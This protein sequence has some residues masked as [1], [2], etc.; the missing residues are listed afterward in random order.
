MALAIDSQLPAATALRGD[1]ISQAFVN[2]AGTVMYAVCAATDQTGTVTLNA[3]TYNGVALTLI[4]SQVSYDTNHSKIGLYRLLSPAT[5]SNTF[6]LSGSGGS[7]NFRVLACIMTFTGN[8]TSTPEGTL[9]SASGS[10]AT[11]ATGN[12]TNTSGNYLISGAVTGTTVPVA[13][14]GNTISSSLAGSANTGG[15]NI[16]MQYFA[17]TGATRNMQMTFTSDVWGTVGVEV[18]APVVAGGDLTVL[19]GEPLVSS[20]AF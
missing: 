9:A 11:A 20:S 17:A 10:S 19:A 18:K 6:A 5:G 4:G 7:G 12:I 13:G 16:G 3:P 2:T 1:P 8:D 15:D 14:S